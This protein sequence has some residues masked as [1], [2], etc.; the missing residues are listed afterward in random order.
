MIH[1]EDIEGAY[2]REVAEHERPRALKKHAGVEAQLQDLIEFMDA[3][4]VET[5]LEPGGPIDQ[6]VEKVKAKLRV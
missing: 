2:V 6:N 3:T 4:Y 5:K 1:D